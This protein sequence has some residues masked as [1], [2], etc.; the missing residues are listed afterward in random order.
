MTVNADE[1][2][3]SATG[4]FKAKHTDFGMDPFTAMLG[5]LKNENEMKFTASLKGEPE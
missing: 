1:A 3:F 5:A 2:S 4:G